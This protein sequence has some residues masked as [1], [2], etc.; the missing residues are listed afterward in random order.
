MVGF[1]N[2]I[3]TVS[4]ESIRCEWIRRIW[5]PNRRQSCNGLVRVRG[6]WSCVYITFLRWTP[7]RWIAGPLFLP[8]ETFSTGNLIGLFLNVLALDFEPSFQALNTV[9][10]KRCFVPILK[11][12]HGFNSNKKTNLTKSKKFNSSANGDLLARQI[13]QCSI[14]VCACGCVRA[15]PLLVATVPVWSPE[16]WFLYC[17][18]DVYCSPATTS[19]SSPALFSSCDYSISLYS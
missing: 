16:H 6:A 19:R 14:N 15:R 10:L 17:G 2:R 13:C 11:H 8:C 3:K 18:D 1:F 9:E 4:W 5:R 7:K 12:H